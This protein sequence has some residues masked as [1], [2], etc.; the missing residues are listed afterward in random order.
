MS[1][2]LWLANSRVGRAVS[3]LLA[4]LAAAGGVYL[5]GRSDA[6]N[7]AEAKKAK[8]Y[9]DT[10]KRIDETDVP[11]DDPSVLRDWLRERGKR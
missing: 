3:A 10:R 8:D 7:K 9:V 1:V 11:S 4:F 5:K 6:K 2:L